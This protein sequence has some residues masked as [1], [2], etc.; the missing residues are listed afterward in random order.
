MSGFKAGLSM[1]WAE[2]RKAS[3]AVSL[4]LF[5]GFLLWGPNGRVPVLDPIFDGLDPVIA[6]MVRFA[7]AAVV[8]V[9]F[10]ALVLRFWQNDEPRTFAD[11]GL[12]LGDWK[13]GLPLA[14]G[15]GLALGVGMTFMGPGDPALE[16]EYPLYGDDHPALGLFVA[17][18][19][20]YLLFFMANELGMRGILLFGLRRWTGSGAAAV[21]LAAIPQLVWHLHKPAAEMWMA[22]FWGLAVGALALR[23]GS[24]WWAVI[25]HWAS[26][27]ALDV[28][29]RG[30]VG[31]STTG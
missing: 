20:A 24:A 1:G 7:V 16:G 23:L 9:G 21:V 10:P 2:R 18:E 6:W 11:W 25:F 22:G 8:M 31:S 12:G 14:L 30:A 27:V 5:V 28:A 3:V 15:L 19:T 29:L 26:N 13:L 4:A 17:Y